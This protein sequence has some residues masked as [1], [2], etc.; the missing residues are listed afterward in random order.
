MRKLLIGCVLAVTSFGLGACSGSEA[1]TELV[2]SGPWEL[3]DKDSAVSFVSVK[4][5]AVSETHGFKFLIGKINADGKAE[6][7]IILDSVST[8]IDIRDSRMRQFVFETNQHPYVSITA[9]IDLVSFKSI[10]VGD[11]QDASIFLNLDMHGVSG[12]VVCDIR[13]S[14]L[15]D[16][17]VR[18]ETRAPIV[19][20]AS[21]YN[22]I[23]GI[24]RLQ[25]LAGLD[26]ISP[27]VPVTFSLVFEAQD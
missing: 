16:G 20:S 9:D 8:N 18:V 17:R 10:S 12:S 14:N 13:V 7:K 5:N 26:A 11:G 2:Y 1:E 19:I 25:A 3:V 24:N 6:L 23:G 15:G 4:N 22:F 21:D 27:N